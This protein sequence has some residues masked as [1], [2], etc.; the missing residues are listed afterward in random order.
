M[1]KR[2]W[3]VT[4]GA[5]FIGS[6][7]TEELVRIGERVRVFDNFSTGRK[8]NLAALAGKFE[9]V[10]GDLRRP[11]DLVRAM[12]GVTY[13]LH[14]AAFRSVPKSV[15]NPRAANDNNATGTLNALMAAKEAG[16]KRFVYAATSSAYGECR[17]FPQRESLP[18][19]P[20]S[21]YAVSKLAGEHYCHVFA[22][23]YGLETVALRYFN[24]FGPRQNPESVYSAV[25][26]RFMELAAQGKPLEIHWDGRQ[27][28]DFTFVAN[29]VDA[30]LRAARSSGVSGKTYN[31][32][33]GSNISLLDIVKE[34]ERIL[35]RKIEKV[36]LPRRR[37][38]IRKTY[39]DISR[40]RRELGFKPQVM[41]A[42]GLGLTWDYFS[43]RIGRRRVCG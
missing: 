33:T 12:K 14:Q 29:V 17:V 31:V 40:A 7:I 9:L 1:K 38:D 27:S 16:V 41:F 34:L 39:A 22:K 28:R 3:L 18:T 5:G 36:F 25:I 20:V 26:P 8:E 35:G 13:V 32:A 37:G 43:S 24:V 15:D 23:T 2:L 30:N 42:E 21:P 4:G 11:R 6:N 10:K 19:A